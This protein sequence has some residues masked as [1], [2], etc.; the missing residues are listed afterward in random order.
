[1][2]EAGEGDAACF[3]AEDEMETAV[4][5]VCVSEV[6]GKGAVGKNVLDRMGDGRAVW[7]EW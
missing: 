2:E 6:E 5:E 1:M 4:M 7:C 3:C